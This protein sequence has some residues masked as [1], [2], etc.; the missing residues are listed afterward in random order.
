M[1]SPLLG[2]ENGR[3]LV[4]DEGTVTQVN[5][6]WV[7]SQANAYLVKLFVK[8]A[9]YSGVSSGSKRLPLESQLDG[10]MLPGAS[11][12]QFY[13]R[14]YALEYVI[15]PGAW[16]LESSD[17]TGLTWSAVTTQF[18]W[19]A[20]GTECRFRFGQDPLLPAAKIQRSSGVF[21]GQGIDEII[22]KEIGGVEIQLTGGE[23]QN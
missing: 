1:T 9:Q 6:R 17:E 20:P 16:D 8:R 18:S 12:D 21:G 13:Y 5:G 11:G 4:P 23:V 7:T 19:L 3:L 22:Y 14:G 10:N 2:Y 15:V